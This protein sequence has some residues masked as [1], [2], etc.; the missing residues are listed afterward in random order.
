MKAPD[1][2]PLFFDGPDEAS[3]FGWLHRPVAGAAPAFGL[4]LCNPFGFESLSAHR[5]LRCVAEAA[6]AAGCP[7]LR[8]DYAGTGDSQGDDFDPEPVAR[9]VRSVHAAIETLKAA[10]GVSRVCLFGVRLGATLATLAALERSDVAGLALMA[11]VLRGRAYLR[12][13]TMLTETGAGRAAGVPVGPDGMVESGGFLLTR[14]AAAALSAI[15][16]RSLPHA[17]APRVLLIERDDVSDPIDW[18][19]ALEASGAAVTRARWP[20]YAAMMDD[21]QRSV[22]PQP[23]ID[24]LLQTLREWQSAQGPVAPPVATPVGRVAQTGLGVRETAV[25][26]PAGATLLFGI[27][28]EP[29]DRAGPRRGMPAVLLPNA[30]SIHRIGPDRLWVRLARLWA[31]RGFLVLRLDL[32]GIGDSRAQP[33]AQENVVYSAHASSDMAAA[34]DWLTRQAGAGECHVVGLCSGA[35]HALKAAVAGPALASAV[36]INPLTYFW[37]DGMVL[38]DVKDYQ[39]FSL[40]ESFRGKALTRGPWRKLLR[41]ELHVRIIA[42]VA[43]R[44]L[45]NVVSPALLDLARLMRFPLKDDLSQHLHRAAQH[46]VALHFVFARH[47]PG[48]ALLRTQ[49]GRGLTALKQSGHATVDVIDGADHIFTRY[50]AREQLVRSLDALLSRLDAPAATRLP[51]RI[52]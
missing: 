33:G 3:L 29:A 11:P 5:G 2:A 31:A 41:G 42:K 16:L 50:Q 27:L 24:G 14:D 30:G 43:A 25:S 38:C 6:A 7:A 44:R 34:I 22:P 1:A 51:P 49:A 15:D 18:L 10:T 48:L 9:W 12:E 28:A 19:P 52:E 37:H 36:M 23:V 47:A 35:Y 45:L 40:M 8:F 13:L 21:P 17:P 32:S 39:V 26:I 4:V 46:G 20:G